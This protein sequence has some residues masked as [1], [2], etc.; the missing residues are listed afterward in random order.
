[1]IAGWTACIPEGVA[2]RQIVDVVTKH[3]R[4]RPQDRHLTAVS[5]V[6]EALAEAFPCR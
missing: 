2:K 1:M 4:E 3:L 6:A 5:I